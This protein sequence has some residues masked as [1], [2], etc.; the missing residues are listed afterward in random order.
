[1]LQKSI[2]MVYRK[3]ESM[4][5]T[6]TEKY[7]YS[8]T[9]FFFGKVQ[10][11]KNELLKLQK[12]I[13][14]FSNDGY[15]PDDIA[16]GSSG[17][18]NNRSFPEYT[19]MQGAIGNPRGNKAYSNSDIIDNTQK[20]QEEN[21]SAYTVNH[22]DITGLWCL[23]RLNGEDKSKEMVFYKIT[24]SEMKVLPYGDHYKDYNNYKY[25]YINGAVEFGTG[26][27][28]VRL[29]HGYLVLSAKN[30]DFDIIFEHAMSRSM[31]SIIEANE[32]FIKSHQ[33]SSF[34]ASD[35]IHRINLEDTESIKFTDEERIARLIY[36]L[37]WKSFTYIYGNSSVSY[38]QKDS[39]MSFE[40][41]MSF[42]LK[43][44]S[45]SYSGTYEIKNNNLILNYDDG[46]RQVHEDIYIVYNPVSKCYYL[47]IAEQCDR[48]N[49]CYS[50][51]E[52]KG[53]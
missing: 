40:Q 35:G 18:I 24:E 52:G 1:M 51:F 50:V 9:N 3:K 5:N 23:V 48:Y 15:H 13:Y 2:K 10:S 43:N 34:S 8:S 32:P 36:R 30:Y 12:D 17:K 38:N 46:F 47:Y 28:D 29:Q 27:F 49:G 26:P 33:P 53:K 39:Q 6:V 7:K 19:D 11:M 25:K 20:S 42:K 41:D 14:S 4:Q 44:N 22:S 16:K 37:E 31:E 21:S 45:G